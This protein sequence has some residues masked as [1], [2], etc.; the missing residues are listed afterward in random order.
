MHKPV[1][2]LGLAAVV[3]CGPPPNPCLTGNGGCDPNATCSE[4]NNYDAVC[5]CNSGYTLA[6]NVCVPVSLC[7]TNNGGCD[8]N[9]TCTD[10]GNGSVTCACNGGYFG[11]GAS[12]SCQPI[13]FAASYTGTVT[14]NFTCSGSAPPAFIVPSDTLTIGVDGSG[15]ATVS[16]AS[17]QGA[18]LTGT[19]SNEVITIPQTTTFTCNQADSSGDTIAITSIGGTLTLGAGG[20]VNLSLSESA[21][22]NNDSCGGSATGTL[23]P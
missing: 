16:I 8:T 4:D 11:S 23:S 12:G 19:E 10:N 15:N 2:V 18:T 17:C 14:E 1:G 5:T 21:T 9:A 6:A 3:S 7:A 22:V 20:T 13:G